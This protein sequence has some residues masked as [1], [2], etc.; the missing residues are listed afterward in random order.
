MTSQENPIKKSKML[1]VH[2]LKYSGIASDP[3]Y[4]SSLKSL[5][6]KDGDVYYGTRV[7]AHIKSV[8]VLYN[9]GASFGPHASCYWTKLTLFLSVYQLAR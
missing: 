4:F 1:E 8:D 7:Q 3:D 9:Y 6:I 2:I 5:S